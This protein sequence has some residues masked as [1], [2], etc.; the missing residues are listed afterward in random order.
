MT[1]TK[2]IKSL[3]RFMGYLLSEVFYMVIYFLLLAF[4]TLEKHYGI[5]ILYIFIF[6]YVFMALTIYS[7][8]TM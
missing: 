5:I 6:T 4:K 2:I 1:T 7:Y 3:G 8:K